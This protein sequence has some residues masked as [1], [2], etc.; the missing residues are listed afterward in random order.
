MVYFEID[1]IFLTVIENWFRGL[2]CGYDYTW[3]GF[4]HE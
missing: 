1:G 4:L 2:F 3:R